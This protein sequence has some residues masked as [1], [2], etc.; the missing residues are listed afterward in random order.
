MTNRQQVHVQGRTLELSNLDKVLYPSSGF[1]KGQVLDYYRRAATWLLPHLRARP[2][3]LKRYPD[4]VASEY[5]YEKRCPPHKPEW[6]VTAPLRHGDGNEVDYCTVINLPS[7]MWVANLASLEL[8]VLLC[9]WVAPDRPTA[10]VFD[11]DP[12]PPAGLLDCARVALMLRDVCRDVGLEA[13]A[14]ISGKKGMHFYVPTNTPVTFDQTKQFARTIA[15]ALEKHHGELVTSNMSKSLRAGKV[16][17]DWSQNDQHKTTVCV[18]SLRAVDPPGV[19]APVRWEEIQAAVKSGKASRLI[20]SPEQVLQRLERDGDLFEPVLTVRQR[21]PGVHLEPTDVAATWQSRSRVKAGKWP[22]KINKALAPYRRKRSFSRTAEPKG[23][24]ARG[25]HEGRHFVIQKHAAKSLHYD[26][27][28]EIG[29]VLKS[30]AVPKGPSLDPRNKRLAVMTEDHP[31][32]YATFEGQIPAGQYGAGEVIVWDRG[33]Y[34][35]TKEND[36]PQAAVAQG[37]LEFWL[38]G[39]KL[40]GGFV[41][42]RTGADSSGK[43]Q[44]LLIKRKDDAADPRANP[45]RTEPQSVISGLWVE[46]LKA[47]KE[48]GP[49][50]AFQ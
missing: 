21:L 35:M 24:G 18:Y 36:A 40:H 38:E 16:F 6:I 12:G 30:W 41:L 5:F 15:L 14:K 49:F 46:D 10:V 34:R 25:G 23:T 17:I 43:E 29:G 7:L 33:T 3:T 45:V 39:T 47:E 19:S 48:S 37:R 13:F 1:V 11:L 42:I 32:E 44:W 2:L 27:R 4:G 31:L 50:S 26:F 9:R 28:L 20:F 22:R 8:H